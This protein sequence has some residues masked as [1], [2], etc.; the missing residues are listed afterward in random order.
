MLNNNVIHIF[1][2]YIFKPKVYSICFIFHIFAGICLFYN[3]NYMYRAPVQLIVS[4]TIITIGCQ[5]GDFR[6]LGRHAANLRRQAANFTEINVCKKMTKI[7]TFASPVLSET[8]KVFTTLMS[9]TIHR[10]ARSFC[11]SAYGKT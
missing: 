5:A 4:S 6:L 3:I 9:K 10:S 2:S 7:S 11:Q 8:S 1:I